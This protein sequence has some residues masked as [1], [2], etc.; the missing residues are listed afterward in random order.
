MKFRCWILVLLFFSGISSAQDLDL[1]AQSFARQMGV[2][3][4]YRQTE[5]SAYVTLPLLPK[6]T[7]VF[8]RYNGIVFDDHGTSLPFAIFISPVTNIA[9][10]NFYDHQLPQFHK[11]I[12]S[13]SVIYFA[14]NT[15]SE[16]INSM[17]NIDKVWVEIQPY[18]IEGVAVTLVKM[19]YRLPKA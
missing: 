4:K 12:N 17:D 2:P 13:D 5:L 1:L 7:L 9:T 8:N 15:K 14:E 16:D 3:E 11:V 19:N 10:V 6:S 18:I